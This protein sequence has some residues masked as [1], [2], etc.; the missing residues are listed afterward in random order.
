MEATCTKSG[1]TEGSHCSVCE[2]TLVQQKS[3]PAK[4]HERVTDETVEATC[5]TPGLTAG[6]HCS[7]CSEVLVE[8]KEI[9]A[10]GHTEVVDEALEATCT[11][12]GFTEGTHCSVCEKVL[13]EQEE[14]PMLEHEWGTGRVSTVPTCEK[15]GV[16]TFTCA[17]CRN[18]KE[19][20]EPKLE[21]D[22]KK[23]EARKPTYTEV[24]WEAYESCAREGCNYTTKVEIPALGEPVIDS[25]DEFIKNLAILEDIT[26]TYVKKVSPGKDP[27]MLMVK[28]IRTGVER[29]NSGSWNIMAGYEDTDF[30]KYVAK[31]EA[32]YNLKLED[33][34]E[35]M[36]V[37]GLKNLNVFKLPNGDEA[38]I[39]H[40]FGTMDISYTNASSE[41]HADVAGWGG[42][43][44]DLISLA[45]QFGVKADTMEGM[46]AEIE[47]LYFGKTKEDIIRDYGVE[48]TE[49]SFSYTD[50][51][52]DLDG[53]YIMQQIYGRDYEKGTM[54]DILG[55]YLTSSLNMEQRAS[56]FLKKRL[57]GVS[58]RTEVRDTVYN[59]YVTN[60]VIATLEGTR[61]YVSDNETIAKIR[62]ACCYVWADYL[63]KLAGD[64]VEIK[65]NVYYDV[66]SSESSTL[67]PGITQ[68]IK[69]AKTADDKQMKF[70]LATADLSNENVQIYANY[71]DNDPSKGWGMSRTTSQMN[72]AQKRYGDPESEEYIENYNVIAGINA[73]GYNMSTGQPSGLLT[74][75]GVEYSP[76]SSNGFFGILD[77]GS[78][79]IGT[80][81]DYYKYKDRIQEAVG[82]FGGTPIIKD[83]KVVGTPSEAYW[84]KRYS[85]TAIGITKT[86]KVV[87][88]V[89]DGRQGEFS[90][91]GSVEEVAQ[92]MLEAGC[93]EA[94]H[95][96]GGGSS[97]YAARPEGEEEIRVVNSPCD[98]AERSV[99]SS[100]MMV[101][102]AP[103]STAFDRAVLS[104]EYSYLA[105]GA[106]TQ[107]TATAVSATGNVVDMPEGVAWEISDETIGKITEDGTFTAL[108][109]G[110][111]DVNL[112]LDGTVIG[113]RKVHVVE[114][115]NVYF[116]KETISAI[117]GQPAELP[118]KAVYE[119]KQVAI[120]EKDVVLS[121]TNDE[122]GILDG[123]KFTAN[124]E[125][126]LRQTRIEAALAHDT[127]VTAMITIA[128]FREDEAS[129]NFEKATG[130]DYQLAWNREVSNSE[131]EGTTSYRAINTEEEMV[132]SYTFA[133]DMSK[134]DIPEKL[135]DLTYMLPGADLEGASAWTFLMQ[136]AERISE[137]TNVTATFKFD[138]SVEVD[139]SELTVSNEY[140]KLNKINGVTFDKETNTLTLK[141]A[142]V[143]QTEPI[144]ADTA[145]LL[146]ILSGLKLTPKEEGAAWTSA[147][148]LSLVHEG[149]IS[150]DVYM[151]ANELYT[152]ALREENQQIYDLYPFENENVKP[153][154]EVERGGHFSAVYKD[155]KDSYTLINAE[156][157]GWVI[158]DK[159]YA[160]YENGEKYVGIQQVDGYY[161]DFG[162]KG[163]NSG[164]EKY[165]GDMT[166]KDGNEYYI[167]YGQKHSG[168]L[169]LDEEV[170]YYN[171]E[172]SIREE[173][174]VEETPSTC[175]ADGHCIYTTKSGE[176]KRVNYD[177]AGG[178]EYV[179]QE[180]GSCVCSV[181]GHVRIEME[182]CT[183]KLGT[184]VYTY[185]GKK[186]S[187]STTVKSK[188]GRTLIRKGESTHPD[189][190]VS[191][192]N[193]VDVG[194]AT[195]TMTA[196]KY[197][198]YVDLTTW[199]GNAAG[200]TTRTYEIRPDL[201]TNVKVTKKDKT[202]KLS[203]TAAKAPEVTYVIYR[204][205]DGASWTKYGETKNKT[206]TLDA[207]ADK[208]C[209]F[210]VG[211]YKVVEGKTYKSVSTTSN[212]SY[213]CAVFVG[214]REDG[215]PTLKW[216]KI[217]G[218]KSYEV[219]RS[220]KK[221]SDF[222]KVS[223]TKNT[224]YSH[225][226][227]KENTTYYYYVRAVLSNGTKVKSDIVSNVRLASGSFKVRTSN[228]SSDG[229]PMFT[230]S[231][232]KGAKSYKIYRATS[233]NGTYKSL[234]TTT[235]TTYTNTSATAGYTYYYKVKA[236]L[237]NSKTKIS[238][239]V[240]NKALVQ[241]KDF[242]VS[243]KDNTNG[244]PK[245]TWKSN[246]A[247]SY[248][249]YRATSQ[250]GT[251]KKMSTV[252]GTSYTNTS[253]VKGKTYYYKVKA[254]FKDGNV[255]YS[256]SY[257]KTVKK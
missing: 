65:E 84:D 214:N 70:Y 186:K 203:W 72:A 133:I 77:D 115:D 112:V 149:N 174:K 78:A 187:P 3:I 152:F 121:L 116:D 36:A 159:G 60:S 98:G 74:M 232:V 227:S 27:V 117:Y 96:D 41:A 68:E 212:V 158:E 178:H 253:A 13:V 156:K 198:A 237:S 89:L 246:G 205:A 67:A 138:P 124:E 216:C 140:F 173:L 177:D 250:N 181:C 42:D 199:R 193:N 195:V 241:D 57:K 164:K 44:A 118:V 122:S 9:E 39:G 141:L 185:N 251:Y 22:L 29:Y 200:S 82:A 183:V 184:T 125:S 143:D 34:E 244:Q 58:L 50:V 182:E 30:A 8:Q 192:A 16:R 83:G 254:T 20:A 201:P 136:L 191:Y 196:S 46:V 76:I 248:T 139:Y 171:P 217:S 35:L 120:T 170:R 222:K 202:V 62:E 90:C 132:T 240:R 28:Y 207:S 234:S 55:G 231:K 88:M 126:G 4:G 15:E 40:V 127:E 218:A 64:Y 14:I 18:T 51:K 31:Y 105:T 229:K 221:N 190:K 33:G 168:W 5:E 219:Y 163:I 153:G 80:Q 38:D 47:E 154:E 85:R 54:T 226:S 239:V 247:V 225:T 37:T 114:P 194:T 245:L 104:S 109:L 249:I 48:P 233:P 6:S 73:S 210:K 131:L 101:S 49:G 11:K 106:S 146:C 188:D 119:G 7:V 175:I 161:Y 10:K 12:T 134:I 128:L 243:V 92:I 123:F 113:T 87:F 43:I 110:A 224:S 165:T 151:R 45:D 160:Y 228:R 157:D 137:L 236:T 162:D 97:T 71:K 2:K 257:K 204:S 144:D 95:L 69:L 220:T 59:E 166:D 107:F 24:G 197:G 238:G 86:G 81:S 252:K 230:W 242:V 61:E 19:E 155:F 167:R 172:T 102:T 17:V 215:V 111:V 256:K 23:H 26:D 100:L 25:Y 150:Y 135:Q 145:N 189:Y 130:G 180:D 129:F 53:Y 79:M 235:K 213:G 94:I 208:G 211:T 99:S 108:Q 63:C 148:Q 179:E 21:H 66:F 52:G 75:R 255:L 103:S 176:V 56:Y 93:V 142:W 147:K 169:T 91:G 32:D 206:F 223:T 1:L 209:A